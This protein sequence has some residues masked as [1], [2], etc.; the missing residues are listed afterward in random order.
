MSSMPIDPR[1]DLDRVSNCLSC[2]A[3]LALAV[4]EHDLRT[5]SLDLWVAGWAPDDL[6]DHVRST[7][8]DRRAVDLMA[9]VLLVDDSHR[10]DQSRPPEWQVVIDRLR[11]GTGA[12]QTD[13]LPGWLGRWLIERS[14]LGTSRRAAELL[15]GVVDALAELVSPWPEP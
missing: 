10:S 7:V 8:G 12:V 2:Q 5:M 6:L 3:Q 9:L 14:T 15:R 13:L 4:Y 11:V 1:D